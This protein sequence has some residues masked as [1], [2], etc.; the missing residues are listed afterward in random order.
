MA[1]ISFFV[2]IKHDSHFTATTWSIST[3]TILVSPALTAINILA[4]PTLALFLKSRLLSCSSHLHSPCLAAPALVGTNLALTPSQPPLL[5]PLALVLVAPL[6]PPVA[7]LAA[8]S[9]I[10]HPCPHSCDP[11]TY[12]YCPSPTLAALFPV[13][14]A[15]ILVAPSLTA[16]VLKAPTLATPVLTA[17]IPIHTIPAVPPS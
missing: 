4:A 12:E 13:L 16:A 14:M 8:L 2:L 7:I 6:Q 5:R 9:W 11:H 15:I 1:P 10:F 3:V 17:P